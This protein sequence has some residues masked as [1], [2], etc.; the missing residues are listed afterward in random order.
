MVAAGDLTAARAA[1]CEREMRQ[2]AR[3]WLRLLLPS[4]APGYEAYEEEAARYL[5]VPGA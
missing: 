5:G 4:L 3:A 1:G 2:A